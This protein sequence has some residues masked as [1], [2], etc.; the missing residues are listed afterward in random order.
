MIVSHQLNRG[1]TTER[2]YRALCADST[3]AKSL[4]YG[5][6]IMYAI[7]YAYGHLGTVRPA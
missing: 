7:P 2:G 4:W 3:R 6:R 1:L 5:Y